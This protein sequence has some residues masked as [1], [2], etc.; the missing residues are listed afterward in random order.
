MLMDIQVASTDLAE[1]NLRQRLD[2]LYP[3]TK[4]L[5]ALF[6]LEDSN[7]SRFHEMSLASTIFDSPIIGQLPPRE[8]ERSFKTFPLLGYISGIIANSYDQLNEEN[9]EADDN[10]LLLRALHKDLNGK[11]LI[12]PTTG[13]FGIGLYVIAKMLRGK[14]FELDGEKINV[15]ALAVIAPQKEDSAAN[16]MHEMPYAK[17]RVVEELHLD[18]GFFYNNSEALPEYTDRSTRITDTISIILKYG[19]DAIF[20]PTNPATI[21]E[22]KG[23]VRGLIGLAST[24]N[25]IP[26]KNQKQLTDLGVV[27]DDGSVLITRPFGDG[28]LGSAM[29]IASSVAAHAQQNPDQIINVAFPISAGPGAAG[30]QYVIDK[31]GL[32]NVRVIASPDP[33]N[34]TWPA[35]FEKYPLEG[36]SVTNPYPKG[37]WLDNEGVE[38]AGKANGMGSNAARDNPVSYIVTDGLENDTFDFQFS[39][40]VMRMIARAIH[41]ADV[42]AGDTLAR[43]ATYPEVSAA[44]LRNRNLS[45]KAKLVR[46]QTAWQ[47]NTAADGIPLPEL[48]SA[49]PLAALLC[50]H[51]ESLETDEDIASF[52]TRVAAVLRHGGI[53]AEYFTMLATRGDPRKNEIAQD[54]WIELE[55]LADIQGQTRY[56]DNK[57]APFVRALRSAFGLPLEELPKPERQL[58]ADKEIVVIQETGY[59]APAMFNRARES[60]Q[61]K[62]Q[63]EALFSQSQ[64]QRA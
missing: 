61:R 22:F 1:A 50:K 20:T 8:A 27:P 25:D 53:S 45:Y 41:A 42:F 24:W 40:D 51:I 4:K 35:Y 64:L 56:G 9:P 11:V 3:L 57:T 60:A 48:A 59:N 55:N 39:T 13:S 47:D 26:L 46:L 52:A 44:L 21:D 15:N 36:H 32:R 23:L 2:R 37:S 17:Y 28:I 34:N 31:M 29:S 5:A 62:A 33:D 54:V 10:T 30:L 49:T 7:F 19:G 16:T 58:D 18:Q 38:K 63:L 14:K 6:D 12:G 43:A